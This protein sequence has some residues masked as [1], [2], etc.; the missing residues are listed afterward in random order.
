[1]TRFRNKFG[2][3]LFYLIST[4]LIEIMTFQMLDIGL[5]PKNFMYDLGLILMFVGIIF[6]IPNYLAQ[7]I[8][9]M[10]MIIGI[11]MLL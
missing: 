2:L 5:L 7:Y 9:S 1:M 11:E 10:I 3:S 6:I 4:I 8:V